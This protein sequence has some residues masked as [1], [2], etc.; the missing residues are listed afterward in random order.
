MLFL[1]L[2]IWSKTKE[3]HANRGDRN[4]EGRW[5]DMTEYQTRGLPGSV[6]IVIIKNRARIRS[7]RYFMLSGTPK[8]WPR[9][10]LKRASSL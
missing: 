3:T 8:A 2:G 7:L 10:W 6:P 5:Y 9:L 4:K 1:K